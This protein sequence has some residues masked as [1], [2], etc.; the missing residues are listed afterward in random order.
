MTMT[1][2]HVVLFLAGAL[3]FL[4]FFSSVYAEERCG[5]RGGEYWWCNPG[6]EPFY[7]DRLAVLRRY[8]GS[9][10]LALDA[11]AAIHT[12]QPEPGLM[13]PNTPIVVAG[14][15]KFMVTGMTWGDGS[16]LVNRKPVVL[17]HDEAQ[18]V[19]VYTFTRDGKT[20]Y[21]GIPTVC[22][23]PVPLVLVEER[24]GA[25]AEF[26][27]CVPTQSAIFTEN[28][29]LNWGLLLGADGNSGIWS[30]FSPAPV[31]IITLKECH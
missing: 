13:Q 9:D 31:D 27:T 28:N 21:V 2:D 15:R 5:D 8:F 18:P 19:K 30:G 22:G 12:T 7:G 29:R 3:L 24:A 10:H 6:A 23:N 26:A 1:S 4:G 20:Y 25:D 14:N 16:R 17:A 11:E